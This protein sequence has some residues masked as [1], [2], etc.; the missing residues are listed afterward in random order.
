[1]ST[2]LSSTQFSGLSFP[3]ALGDR[4]QCRHPNY[5]FVT[6]SKFKELNDTE[7]GISRD[8]SLKV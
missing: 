2:F 3:K 6:L 4:H 7:S 1:M 8:T 5:A